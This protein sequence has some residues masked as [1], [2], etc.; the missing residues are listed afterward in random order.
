MHNSERGSTKK[1]FLEQPGQRQSE[2]GKG[3]IFSSPWLEPP[4]AWHSPNKVF[5]KFSAREVP[6]PLFI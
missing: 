6:D 5:E 3:G 2:L 4:T 1:C